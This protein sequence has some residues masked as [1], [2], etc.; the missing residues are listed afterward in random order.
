MSPHGIAW[1]ESE[2]RQL[3]IKARCHSIY[4]YILCIK[5]RT[6]SAAAV[7]HPSCCFTDLLRCR[8]CIFECMV[9]AAAAAVL[10]YIDLL[11][12]V[13]ALVAD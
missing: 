11:I 13:H 12:S 4:T 9:T 1:P 2:R 3:C 5:L 7:H 10:S 6:R 8:V